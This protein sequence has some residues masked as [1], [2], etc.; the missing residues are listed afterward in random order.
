LC[1]KL[2]AFSFL[3]IGFWATSGKQKKAEKTE[4]S[5]KSYT[6]SLDKVVLLIFDGACVLKR[7]ARS[8]GFWP[9]CR[10]HSGSNCWCL[11]LMPVLATKDDTLSLFKSCQSAQQGT[12][13]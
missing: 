1:A 7:G 5:R 11:S 8:Q 2:A 9:C 10:P 12:N 3:S 13:T 4:E 6:V